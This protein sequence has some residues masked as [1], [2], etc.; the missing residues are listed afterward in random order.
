MDAFSSL[1]PPWNAAG[2][3]LR[4]Y[5]DMAASAGKAARDSLRSHEHFARACVSICV[6]YALF[7]L[8]LPAR[9]PITVD[10]ITTSLGIPQIQHLVQWETFLRAHAE[11]GG[12]VSMLEH[13]AAI[14]N[15]SHTDSP[16]RQSEAWLQAVRHACGNSTNAET[17]VLAMHRGLAEQDSASVSVPLAADGADG[18]GRAF[19]QVY[20]FKCGDINHL[21]DRSDEIRLSDAIVHNIMIYAPLDRRA[22]GALSLSALTHWVPQLALAAALALTMFGWPWVPAK[23]RAPPYGL[24]T[25][26]AHPCTVATRPQPAPRE[27][28][29]RTSAGHGKRPSAAEI[30]AMPESQIIELG[31]RNQIPLYSLESALQDPLRAVKLRRQIVSQHEATGDINFSVDGSALP[32]EGYDYQSVLGACCENVIGYMP[33]PL[34]VAGP[35]KVNGKSVFL[36]MA[37][38]EGAL[39]ASTN[40][41]CMAINAG[42]GV[43]ALLLGDGMTRAPIARFSSLEEAGAAKRWLDSDA[44]FQVIEDCFNA[45]SR[46]ARLQNIKTTVVGSDLY[47]RFTASTGDAMGMNMISK[48]V[49]QAVEAMRKHGFESMEIVSLSGNFCADKKPAAVNWIE[50][51]GKTVSAQATIP[52]QVVQETLKTDVDTLVELN[53]SKNL[54]GSAVA[55]A[56]GG[57]NAHAANVVTAIY[58]ATGQD[59]AQ[60]VQSSSTLT[61]MKNVGGDLQISVFMPSIEVGTV[62]G[63]TVLSPQ[64]AMLGMMGVQGSDP[65]QPGRN[66]QELALLVASGVLAGELSLCSA[67][68]AGSLVKSHLAHNRK[69]E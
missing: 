33:I 39:V 36:P 24:S 20:H 15:N 59:P 29:A 23:R 49:E 54:V 28:A 48:G 41:G 50:G 66:A 21:L 1:A 9:A 68:A 26:T 67:L 7:V 3:F 64:K 13:L 22:S 65:E 42:G 47:I 5:F 14:N 6:S 25:R 46:F 35:I 2:T 45:T 63:G 69:K 57:F 4:S 52:G 12:D 8:M 56:L 43:T 40:R 27:V 18:Q 37:T 16:T 19:Q 53:I 61:V 30:R 51:R 17:E 62:G 32:Y 44:G 38:T 34:G 58:L 60:N 11:S 10:G 55:G 31:T